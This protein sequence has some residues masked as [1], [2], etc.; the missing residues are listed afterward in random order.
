MKIK[1]HRYNKSSHEFEAKKEKG[2]GKAGAYEKRI[3]PITE[4]RRLYERGDLPIKIDHQ[5]PGK[6]ILWKKDPAL[7]DYHLYLPI[8]FDGLRE[9][10]DPCRMMAIYG[11][12][13]LLEKGGAK[14]LPTIPQLIIPMKSKYQHFFIILTIFMF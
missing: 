14:I 6:S 11:V 1:G 7:L 12:F 4:F 5:T 9:K 8:F 10:T 3:V 2:P 13:D